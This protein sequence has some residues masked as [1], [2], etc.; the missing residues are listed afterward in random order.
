MHNSRTSSILSPAASRLSRLA[1]PPIFTDVTKMPEWSRIYFAS[2][3]PRIL[4][5]SAVYKEDVK[6]TRYKGS[7][8]NNFLLV[9]LKNLNDNNEWITYV[10]RE[11]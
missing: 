7:I 6:Q 10:P 4:N 9:F 5:P 3:P 8:Q 11:N 1:K 2:R